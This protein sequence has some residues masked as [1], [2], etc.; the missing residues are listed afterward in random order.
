MHVNLNV[1]KVQI[2]RNIKEGLHNLM[3]NNTLGVKNIT[4]RIAFLIFQLE[5]SNAILN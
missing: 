3:G 4:K 5:N 1:K 2:S